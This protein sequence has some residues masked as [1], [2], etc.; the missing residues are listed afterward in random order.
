[1]GQAYAGDVEP[2]MPRD[3]VGLKMYPMN[4]RLRQWK[5]PSIQPDE[6][7][8][9]M[10]ARSGWEVD[11]DYLMVIGVRSGAKS[12]PNAGALA[13]YERF[14]QRLITSDA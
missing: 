6:G 10:V 8:D 7:F 11:D 12:L 9:R 2:C 14:G 4:E 5:A 1:A 3:E 13:A